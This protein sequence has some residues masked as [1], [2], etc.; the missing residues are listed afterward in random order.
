MTPGDIPPD[1][2]DTDGEQELATVHHLPA[3]RPALEGEVMT[4]EEWREVSQRQR[5]ALRRDIYTT[6][7][8]LVF[9]KSRDVATHP[10]TATGAKLVARNLWYPVAGAGVAYRRWQDTHGA[11]RYE[12]QMRRAEVAGDQEGLREWEARDVAEK[13]RRHARVMDWVRSP[14]DLLRAAAAGLAGF[15]ALLLVLGVVLALGHHDPGQVLAPIVGVI[16][17]VTFV[18]WFFAVYGATFLLAATGGAAAWLWHLGRSRSELPAWVSA[19]A[20]ADAGG[21]D[22]VPDERA[23]TNALRNLNMPALNRKFREGWTPRWLDL[24]VHDG[25]G[26]HSRLLLPE[27]VTVEMIVNSK[28]VLAHNLLRLPVEVWP[29]EPRDKPGV[30]DLWVADQGSLTKPVA[31]WPLLTAGVTDYF[32]GVP[33]AVDP[34]GNVVLGRLFQANWGVAGMMG[35]GKSTLIITALLGAILDP[36]VDIDVYC[37]AVNADYDPLR[38]RLRTLFVSD[39]P[40]EIPT[41]LTALKQLM[42]ELSERG[43][44]LSAAGEPKLTRALAEADPSMRPRVVVIDECQELFVSD[45]GEEA[46]ELVEK[47]VA[48]ARKYGVTLIFATP[49]PSADSLPRKV[50]KVLSNRACFAI[51]DHQG[52]DA[53]LGTGKHKAGI[54]ATTL[55]PMTVAADGT[56]DLGDLGTAMA[57]GFTPADG[58]LRCFYVR[59]GD[60]VD[61]VTPVV[62][63]AMALLDTPPAAALTDGPEPVEQVD[64][65][66]DALTVIRAAG[67]DP[68]MRTQEVLAGLAALRPELYRGWTFER[69]RKELPD[70]ARPYKTRGQMCVNADRLTAAMADRDTPEPADET[71][72]EF[73]TA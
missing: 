42:S 5:A 17:L 36:L 57:S 31:P 30:L 64:Y 8:R 32:K 21:R 34:R 37:M 7:A 11:S 63:R 53:I 55:R 15:T 46:A 9:R 23:I 73:D 49:V 67:P 3:A 69:L 43:R 20:A 38:P 44:K 56:V 51:G 6:D 29:T 70:S 13:A 12:R 52:N 26:W 66:A 2:D 4:V 65:L 39:D 24:P 22:V 62:E 61:D 27:G 33:V 19:P 25:K 71:A 16:D 41:V 72:D 45:V 48:K 40:D 59:R 35:S 1:L 58:L 28:P 10:R 47:I 50:A 14:V 60:G 68:I 54:S 18:C